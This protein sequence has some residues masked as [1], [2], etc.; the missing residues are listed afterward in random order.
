VFW[1]VVT[2]NLFLSGRKPAERPNSLSIGASSSLLFSLP[3]HKLSM[4]GRISPLTFPIGSASPGLTFEPLTQ[5]FKEKTAIS[6]LDNIKRS[7]KRGLLSL[8]EI[9]VWGQS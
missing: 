1:Q 5:K 4:D 6:G 7:H 2:S 9:T 8:S 3:A